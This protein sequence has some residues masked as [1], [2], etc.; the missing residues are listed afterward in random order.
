MTVEKPDNKYAIYYNSKHDFETIDKI[1][2]ALEE[3]EDYIRLTEPMEINFTYL[4]QVDINNEKIKRIDK[5]IKKVYIAAE[6]QVKNLEDIKQKLLAL[7]QNPTNEE[8]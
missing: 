7:P 6:T 5:E 1:N 8:T 3:C 2:N 4:N